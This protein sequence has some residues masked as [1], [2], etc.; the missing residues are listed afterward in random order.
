[1]E[2]GVDGWVIDAV[3]WYVGC[4]WEVNRKYMTDVIAEYGNTYVQP[5]GAGAFLED[6][7]AWITEGNYNSVQDYELFIWWHPDSNVFRNAIDSGDPSLIESKLRNYHDRVREVGGSLYFCFENP[8][9]DD[10]YI[11]NESKYLLY[12]ASVASVGV[13]CAFSE[14]QPTQEA[15]W[16]FNTKAAHP[17]FFQTSLRRMLSTN[18]DHKYYAYLKSAAD[19]SE[20]ILVVLNFQDSQDT[21]RIDCSGIAAKGFMDL[22]S[23]QSLPNKDLIEVEM[24]AYGYRFLRVLSAEK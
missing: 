14:Y 22:R 6:P 19:G 23:N 15:A 12:L 1:M 24:P 4:N 2:T 7:V 5:E 20:R 13:M 3:N 9:G 16:L 17:A 18:D 10:G 8:F 11:Q 21:V